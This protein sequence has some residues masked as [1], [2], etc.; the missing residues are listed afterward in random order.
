M[1]YEVYL[2]GG[3]EKQQD[4]QALRSH[5]VAIAAMVRPSSAV[6]CYRGWIGDCAFAVSKNMKSISVLKGHFIKRS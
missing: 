4:Y 2:T 1:K 3:S 6:D 5:T